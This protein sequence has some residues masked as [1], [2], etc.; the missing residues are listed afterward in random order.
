MQIRQKNNYFFCNIYLILLFLLLLRSIAFQPNNSHLKRLIIF[1]KSNK[2]QAFSLPEIWEMRR[3]SM[4]HNR[5]ACF[6]SKTNY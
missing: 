4:A 5:N 6:Q 3:Q 2:K 1:L